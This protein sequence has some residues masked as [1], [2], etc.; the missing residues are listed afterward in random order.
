MELKL[1]HLFFFMPYNF[2]FTKGYFAKILSRNVQCSGFTYQ[3]DKRF[4]P[5]IFRAWKSSLKNAVNFL[6]FKVQQKQPS[7]TF[8]DQCNLWW[9]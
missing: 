2:A 1:D 4:L 8:I 7:L 3:K 9:W 6:S 5:I